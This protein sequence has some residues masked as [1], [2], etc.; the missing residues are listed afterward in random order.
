MP[1]PKP[2]HSQALFLL[3]TPY[4][5]CMFSELLSF[6]KRGV[7]G[8]LLAESGDADSVPCSAFDSSCEVGI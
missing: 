6:A 2:L 1:P 8:L 5:P 3:R 7:Y 4:S